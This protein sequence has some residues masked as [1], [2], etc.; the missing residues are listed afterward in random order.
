MPISRR[1]SLI[2]LLAG[3]ILF[4]GLLFSRFLLDNVVTPV[5]LVVWVLWRFIRSADQALY[6]NLLIFS[7]LSYAFIHIVRRTQA[8]PSFEQT[9]PSELDVTQE[10]I[11]N[12]W[13]SIRLT[14]DATDKFNLLKRNLGE[15]LAAMYAIKKP[16]VPPFEI[17]A[18]MQRRQIPLP[19]PI[20]TFLFPAQPYGAGRS[21]RKILHAIWQF[22]IKRVRRW[23]GQDKVEYHHSI[24]EVIRFMESTMETKH[25]DEPNN[26][27]HH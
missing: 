2:I 15:M 22:P 24:E 6:W 8:P 7:A 18:A 17:Y 20:Y 16:E 3:L 5:A 12:W 26:T 4:L 13:T 27:Y 9:Q 11:K 1:V 25:G 14:S 19:E 21:L 23:T 10:H